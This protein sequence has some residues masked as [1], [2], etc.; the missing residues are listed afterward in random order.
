MVLLL[1]MSK[2]I[3]GR[4]YIYAHPTNLSEINED[5]STITFSNFSMIKIPTSAFKHLSGCKG[6]TFINTKTIQI[7]PDVWLG[8]S[9][10]E[11]LSVEKSSMTTLD[12]DMF[13]HL[14]SLIMLKVTTIHSVELPYLPRDSIPV[15]SATFRGLDSLNRL[16]LSLPNL[17]ERTF[18]NIDNDTWGDISDTLTE[19][20]LCENDFTEIYDHMFI[21]FLNLRKLS[22]RSNRIRIISSKALHGLE[23]LR[24]IDLSQ[25]RIKDV[26]NDIFQT[27]ASL[28][29]IN[30][31]ENEIEH[32]P[33][34]LLRG[35]NQLKILKLNN[36]RLKTI[37]CNMFDPMNFINTGGHPGKMK[38]LFKIFKLK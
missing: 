32:L 15:K 27:M 7:E 26:P 8:L 25:N 4:E 33:N 28:N 29:E 37:S 16:W 24:E 13:A 31:S 2:D 1:M 3:V 30:L 20:M 12:T 38:I 9:K 19:L 35:I 36:N 11:L 17:N 34:R 10:L 22:F 18:R 5:A 21:Q 14:K 6:L 23:L